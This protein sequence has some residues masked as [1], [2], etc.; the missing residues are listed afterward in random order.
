MAVHPDP[1]SMA[2]VAFGGHRQR[3][4]ICKRPRQL[5]SSVTSEASWGCES[6]LSWFGVSR[7]LTEQL[8]QLGR[9]CTR[10][11]AS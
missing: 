1:V 11:R 10:D 3:S 9:R 2:E 4:V 7:L 6:H 5:S 8:A